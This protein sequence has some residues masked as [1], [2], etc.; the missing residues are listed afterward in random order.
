MLSVNYGI[1]SEY[2]L[3]AIRDRA[4]VSNVAMQTV[5]VVYPS[6][7]DIGCFSYTIDCVGE[8]FKTPILTEL[9]SA[10]ITLFSHS[11]KTRLLWKSR[12]GRSMPTYSATR[13]WSKWEVMKAMMLSFGDIH[14]FLD[15][16]P[17]IGITIRPK[18]LSDEQKRAALQI[19]FVNACYFL[20]GD[21][22]LALHC[23]EAIE[24]V[25]AAMRTAHTPNVSAIDQL[26]CGAPPSDPHHIQWVAYA[27]NCVQ[28][29]LYR[30]L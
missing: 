20:E 4:S 10:W 26:V 21:S 8:K 22:P 23:F 1:R 9:T 11:P 7:L 16:N 14:P 13:W 6:L 3:D 18:L 28:P 25:Y 19:E 30:L 2:L 27:K 15:K 29:G 12:T 5:K 17:D 24:K